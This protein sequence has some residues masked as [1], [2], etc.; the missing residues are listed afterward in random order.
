MNQ[1]AELHP[2]YQSYVKAGL[3]HIQCGVFSLSNEGKHASQL[4]FGLKRKGCRVLWD[5]VDLVWD[6]ETP[7][8]WKTASSLR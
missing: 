1:L 4:I 8:G 2:T 7:S 3:A 5:K 6:V